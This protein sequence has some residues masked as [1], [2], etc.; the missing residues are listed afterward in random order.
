MFYFFSYYL[1][2]RLIKSPWHGAQTTLYCCLEESIRGQRGGYFS[3]CSPKEPSP[4]AQR[5]EDAKA[6]WDLSER[7]TECQTASPL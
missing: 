6:L 2:S 5:E 3:D 1:F 4:F 7:L